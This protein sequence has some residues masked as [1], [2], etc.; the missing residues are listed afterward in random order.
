MWN[1]KTKVIPVI[2]R[3]TGNTSK[4]FGKY[5]SNVT[6]NHEIEELE[7]TAILGTS[8][9]PRKV[10]TQIYKIFN[11]GNNISFSINCK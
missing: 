8:H 3:A 11:M 9:I 2:I 6:G 4:S 10:L 7:K 5:L 1:A